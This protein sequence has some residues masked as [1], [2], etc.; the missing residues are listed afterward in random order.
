MIQREKWLPPL[1]GLVTGWTMEVIHQSRKTEKSHKF[2]LSFIII[3]F[4]GP[5]G[6]SPA[7]PCPRDEQ[8]FRVYRS[9]TQKRGLA[10]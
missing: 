4:K 6:Y 5:M 2:E 10:G 9:G 8:C 7:S 3:N 1:V